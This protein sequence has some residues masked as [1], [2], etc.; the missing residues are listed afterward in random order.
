[1]Y[2]V[3]LREE[4]ATYGDENNPTFGSSGEFWAIN[5]SLTQRFN[6]NE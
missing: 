3:D 6:G 5:E 2:L 1:M 4:S